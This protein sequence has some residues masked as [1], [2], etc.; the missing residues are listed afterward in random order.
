MGKPTA[1]VSIV[2]ATACQKVNHTMWRYPASPRTLPSAPAENE[3][4]RIE[5]TGHT[6][7]TPRNA[8]GTTTPTAT[9]TWLKPDDETTPIDGTVFLPFENTTSAAGSVAYDTTI[10]RSPL[11]PPAVKSVSY[12]CVQSSSTR[13]PLVRRARQYDFQPELP[14]CLIVASRNARPGEDVAGFSTMVSFLYAGLA[15]SA[16]DEGGA[17]RPALPN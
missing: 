14:C 8:H 10:G 11:P 3:R 13:T 7:N 2:D 1:S 6:K 5:I 12:A 9:S 15:R 17:G 4:S 16:I